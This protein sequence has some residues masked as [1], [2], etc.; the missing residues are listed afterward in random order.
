MI[1]FSQSPVVAE[2][3]MTAI[4]TYLITFGYIDG[5]FDTREKVF[6][7]E[8][9]QSLV[10][11]R[12]EAMGIDDPGA[13]ALIVER[14]NLYFE[15]VAGRVEA[16]I[17]QHLDE[18][19]AS[20][21]SAEE[22]VLARLRLRCFELFKELDAS[23]QRALLAIIDQL[24]AADGVTDPREKRFRDE[25]VA[26][27]DDAARPRPAVA[28]PRDAA[29]APRT[30]PLRVTPPAA[31]RGSL[32]NHPLLMM[33]E[34]HFSRDPA[35]LARQIT[36]DH[37]LIRQAI[38]TWD[39][40]RR[41]GDGRL[42]GL[43]TARE[44]RGAP[45]LDKFVYG[46]PAPERETE[47]IVLGDLHGCYSCLKAA[48]LQSDFFGKVALARRDP[49][50]PDVKLVLLGDYIDR[51]M[52]S[53]NGVLRTVLQ[54]FVSMPDSVTVLRGNHEYYLD[55]AGRIVGGVRPAEA[56]STFEHYMPRQMF[57]AY[58]LLFESMPSMLLLDRL[59]FVHAGIPRDRLLDERWRD[60]G[61]LNDKDLRFQM[62]WSDPANA[63]YVPHELQAMNAR[64]S[65]GRQQFKAFMER[66]GCTTLIRGHEK[67]DEGFRVVYDD[68]E[69][70]LLNLFSAGG[71][72]NGDLPV[73][74]SYRSVV[75][76]ALTVKI[77]AGQPA[78]ATPWAID[79]AAYNQP[80]KNGFYRSQPEIEFRVE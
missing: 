62:M 30:P 19:V 45:F 3:Q 55:L 73:N 38:D 27:L 78:V 70:Q 25:L 2:Q 72:H 64:F 32:E 29:S 67:V 13:R 58:M 8:Y 75:P 10:R 23:S 49:R 57:E 28:P 1:A 80:Q 39:Q 36:A 18:V 48:L 9:I 16:E 52:Y 69:T 47:I 44:L 14:Q 37:A 42:D 17:R 71:A 66:I 34:Q 59:L 40:Q 46:A 76:M 53:Y 5:N 26:L 24:C 74:A 35:R 6:I 50:H 68:G 21:E 56:I 77:K 61:S 41:A 31:L 15:R 54:L 20:G 43:R 12:V 22:F 51:G 4:I 11:M 7:H 33:N 63:S 60:L 79:Y 65:F